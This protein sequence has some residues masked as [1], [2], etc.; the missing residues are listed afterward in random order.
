MTGQLAGNLNIFIFFL[1]IVKKI[2]ADYAKIYRVG[3][4]DA[5]FRYLEFHLFIFF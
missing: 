3:S 4:L 2:A 5:G 1:F